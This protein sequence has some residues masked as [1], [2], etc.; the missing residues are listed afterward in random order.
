VDL[1]RRCLLIG[2]SRWHWAEKDSC[3]WKFSHCEPDLRMLQPK[4]KDYFLTWAAVGPQP[5]CDCLDLSSR[6]ENKN[7]P[8]INV[9]HWLGIDRALGA[10][11]ALNRAKASGMRSSGFLVADAGT[12]LS[13]T[14]V[15]SQGEFS[16]GQLV[17]GLR[18][19]LLAMA[20]GAQDLTDPGLPFLVQEPFPC[21]T[22]EAMM[23]G[24]LQALLGALFEAKRLS[25]LPLWLCGGDS[26]LLA[27]LLREQSIEVFHYPNLVLEGMVDVQSR[28]IQAQ[29]H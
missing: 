26:A 16:G 8:L 23:R 4:S 21:Q 9:P 7:V 12:V 1:L 29:D 14:R 6:I 20:Q 15:T 3:D 17:A 25:G 22:S 10:W 5:I 18:L 19:Q 27:D 13:L 2:N 24:S 11:G 28:I